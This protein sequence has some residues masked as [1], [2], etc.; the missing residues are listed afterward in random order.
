MTRFFLLGAIFSFPILSLC[1][2]PGVVPDWRALSA[3]STEVLVI[4]VKNDS[5]LIDPA[6]VKRTSISQQSDVNSR[7]EIPLQNP[8][9]YTLGRVYAAEVLEVLKTK[10]GIRTGQIIQGLR[11]VALTANRVMGRFARGASFDSS[12]GIYPT[13]RLNQPTASRSDA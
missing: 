1:Q 11:L 6:K 4:S 12:R 10:N 3:A 8:S 13:D 7:Q 2:E 5:R 9:E